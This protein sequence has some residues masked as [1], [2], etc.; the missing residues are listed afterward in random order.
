MYARARK[1]NIGRCVIL[2]SSI[3]IGSVTFSIRERKVTHYPA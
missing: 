2:C 1:F 3:P